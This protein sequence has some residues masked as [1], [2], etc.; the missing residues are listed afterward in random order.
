[1]ALEAGPFMR[2]GTRGSPSWQRPSRRHAG[3]VCADCSNHHPIVACNRGGQYVA[4]AAETWARTMVESNIWIKWADV[5][6]SANVSKKASNTPAL[7]SLS[8]RSHTEFHC[9]SVPAAHILHREEVHCFRKQAVVPGLAAP[10]WQASAENLQRA[11]QSVSVIFVDIA[12]LQISRKTR[13]QTGSLHETPKPIPESIRPHRLNSSS[14]ATTGSRPADTPKRTELRRRSIQ[15]G[16]PVGGA[17][18]PAPPSQ[19]IAL[20]G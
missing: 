2:I 11:R 5:L 20:M 4:P 9:Q 8:K 18:H 7:L 15:E 3:Y 1:M 6:I 13:N 19:V 12:D 16:T 10:P 14:P 17:G